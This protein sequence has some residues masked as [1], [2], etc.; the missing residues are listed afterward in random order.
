MSYATIKVNDKVM[1]V[2]KDV[3][4]GVS[5]L[6]ANI[7]HY[8]NSFKFNRARGALSFEW[9]SPEVI[10]VEGY[11]PVN[12]Y[13]MKT[14]DGLSIKIEDRKIQRM[15]I[16]LVKPYL[17][18]GFQNKRIF[19]SK[20][21]WSILWYLM[22]RSMPHPEIPE[23]V[24]ETNAPRQ[25]TIESEVVV[26]GSGIGGLSAA[27][28]AR[29]AGAEVVVLEGDS[30]LG[31]H[32]SYDYSIVENFNKPGYEI[33][34]D[35]LLEAERLNI[36]ILKNTALTAILDDAWIG[37]QFDEPNGN[38]ILIRAKSI[39][40]ASGAREVLTVFGNNDLPGIILGS[41]AL[42]LLNVYKINV[43]KNITVIGSNNWAARIALQLSNKGFKTTLISTS[44][45]IDE[46]YLKQIE[47]S[48]I[49]HMKGY[50]VIEALGTNRVKKVRISNGKETL[51][52][53][54]DMLV[55][56]SLRSPAIEIPSQMGIPLA[57]HIKLGGFLPLHGWGGET[58]FN[59]V[60]IAGELGGIIDEL[61]LM[62]LSKAAGINAAIASGHKEFE[63]Y[64][65]NI[66]EGKSRLSS[67][68]YYALEAL[69]KSFEKNEVLNL[70]YESD[71]L[72]N[73]EHKMSFLCPCIDVTTEDIKT[74]IKER[75]WTEMEKI[76]RYS[77]LGTGRCQGKYCSLAS[78]L[79]ISSITGS[80]PIKVGL[81]RLRPPLIPI[82][83]SVLGSFEQ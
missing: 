58:I 37:I 8:E 26:I 52:L 21:G 48:E 40:I 31:G 36:K 76:K 61:P 25:I 57:F 24:K 75:N 65:E 62:F 77:G 79:Y 9:W 29:E 27:I 59:N 11:G 73:T 20:L 54:T 83:F 6:E 16:S 78:V 60:F 43:G 38:P 56:A 63:K 33:I 46:F 81:F 18:V 45:E 12:H 74:A 14:K 50:R 70:N 55:L 69:V 4:L 42:K 51:T 44:N 13:L 82:S 19:R 64:E 7:I 72:Q 39:V 35:L 49:K 66:A 10:Y 22:K 1:K 23:Q 67:K 68:N 17:K 2:K 15:L 80:L 34:R 28:G 47:S 5:F 30:L 3:P 41:S 71:V 32:L 53:D